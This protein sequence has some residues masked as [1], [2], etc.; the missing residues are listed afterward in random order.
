M[1]TTA[2]HASKAREL[3]VGEL[4]L[5]FDFQDTSE[6][7]V[8][9]GFASVEIEDR[10][11]EVAPPEEFLL[12]NFKAAPSILVN[13]KAW[14][15]ERG[16]PVSAGVPQEVFVARLKNNKDDKTLFNVVNE[17]TGSVE[18]TYP[19]QKVPYLRTGDRGLFAVIRVTDPDVKERVKRG[20]FQAFSW[21]GFSKVDYRL[22]KKSRKV[23]K[24]LRDIDLLEI[25]IISEAPANP[26]ATFVLGSKSIYAIKLEKSRFDSGEMASAYL[27]THGIE[28]KLTEKPHAFLTACYPSDQMKIEEMVS[29][30]MAEGVHALVAP[31][32][33]RQEELPVEASELDT[34]ISL[35]KEERQMA[36]TVATVSEEETET[37][38]APK[39]VS[40]VEEAM[41]TLQKSFDA[42]IKKFESK[43]QET[44]NDFLAKVESAKAAE[45]AE[46]VEES[47]EEV[48]E[49]EAET[50]V[51][52]QN[53]TK[54]N[55][56]AEEVATS[57]KSL[58]S[59][60]E[61]FTKAL[62]E[63]PI[64]EFARSES[65]K[66]SQKEEPNAV[67]DSLFGIN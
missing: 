57:V 56:V 5:A 36:D 48:Q 4:P 30:K 35:E 49:V 28:G 43:Q 32:K 21:K 27:S 18:T 33:E 31:I 37:A 65:T 29:V 17:K 53:E 38:E 54:E 42:A 9:K 44:L 62:K 55:P 12:D 22:N 58:T 64:G 34:L 67:F 10:D 40:P 2:I 52:E 26:S 25:S 19:K 61:S 39:A 47:A 41:Q 16:N 1:P 8:I 14:R 63:A 60:V 7:V 59:V 50:E 46:E 20:E 15:D 6:E 3:F 24:V 45:S 66:S 13:H 23:E 11:G 51:E